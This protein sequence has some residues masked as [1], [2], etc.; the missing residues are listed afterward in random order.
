MDVVHVKALAGQAHGP[1][2]RKSKAAR[3]R[4]APPPPERMSRIVGKGRDHRTH[5]GPDLV[6][7]DAQDRLLQPEQISVGLR[8]APHGLFDRMRLRA[9]Q[10][11]ERAEHVAI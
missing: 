4:A 9:M 7:E 10:L 3:V 11:L 8:A 1:T 6:L 5:S 2:A